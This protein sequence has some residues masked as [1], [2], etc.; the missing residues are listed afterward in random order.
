[1]QVD[2]QHDYKNR[3]M[4]QS[5]GDI[6]TIRTTADVL[7]WRARWTQELKTWHS[8]YKC[9]ID[10]RNLNIIEPTDELKSALAVMFKFLGGLFLRKACGF[11]FDATK[12]HETLPFEVFVSEDEAI[13]ALGIRERIKIVPGDFRSS[14]QFENHFRQHVVEMSFA[15]PVRIDTAEKLAILKDK[16]MNNLMQWH[17]PW[18][19]LVDCSEL[20]FDPALSEDF[21]TMVKY[22]KGLFLKELVGYSPRTAELIYPFKVFRARHKAVT[23]LE[24]EGRISGETA[25]C[26][27]KTTK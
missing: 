10:C 1:M 24:N 9:L 25:N 11:G 4:S 18:N 6:F 26:A 17:S 7:A 15:A 16:L 8:P 20:E 21:N 2:I 3:L 14:I 22:F 23:L 19:L 5:F 12:G 27:T 13:K